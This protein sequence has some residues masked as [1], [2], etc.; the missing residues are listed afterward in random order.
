MKR[1]FTLL[2]LIVV[3]IIVGILGT[4]GFTQYSKVVEK[5]R[6][7]EAKIILGQIRSAQAAYNLE[8]GAYA[9]VITDLAV[10]APTTCTATHFFTYGASGTAG[11]ATRCTTGGKTPAFGT[12][13]TITLTY[14]TGAWGGSAGYY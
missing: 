9:T 12:A 10:E 2:E 8:M 5:G 3:I 6:G 14:A 13:Y 11:T 1:G 7:A 4:L